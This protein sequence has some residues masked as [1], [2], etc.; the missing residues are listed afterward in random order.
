MLGE[1]VFQSE[2]FES[3]PEMYL[4]LP[5][6]LYIYKIKNTEKMI[7]TGKIIIQD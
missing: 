6:G 1:K 4:N 5:A 7:G 3:K 2:I